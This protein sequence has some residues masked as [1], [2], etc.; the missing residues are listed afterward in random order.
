MKINIVAFLAT[1]AVA[2]AN[3]VSLDASDLP[4]WRIKGAL[5]SALV[6]VEGLPLP[7]VQLVRYYPVR[8]AHYAGQSSTMRSTR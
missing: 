7:I 8:T 5:A 1:A 3:L 4:N 2:V 6:R